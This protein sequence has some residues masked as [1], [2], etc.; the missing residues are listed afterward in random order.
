MRCGLVGLTTEGRNFGRTVLSNRVSSCNPQTGLNP[1][2]CGYDGQPMQ[3][4]G[5]RRNGGSN[6]RYDSWRVPMNITLDYEWSCAD[7]QW[8][9]QYGETIQNFF[10]GQGVND[11]V[12]Q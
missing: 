9:R 12:D 8:Q 10:Y 2:L 4:F 1:D 5:G 3:G 7:Q 6:F 11:F